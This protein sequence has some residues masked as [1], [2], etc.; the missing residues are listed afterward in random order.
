[1]AS[2]T[3]LVCGKC[4]EVSKALGNPRKCTQCGQNSVR[5]YAKRAEGK[6]DQPT[7]GIGQR[8][9]AEMSALGIQTEV[10]GVSG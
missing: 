2:I 10:V 4:G 7:H 9:G 1:V 3:A 6:S 5:I 8:S